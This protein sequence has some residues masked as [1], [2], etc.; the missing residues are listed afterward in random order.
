VGSALANPPPLTWS[1]TFYVGPST[2]K[3]FV[4]AL[5]KLNFE[6]TGVMAGFAIDRPFLNLGW[7]VAL[8]GEGQ[9]T[10]YLFGHRDTT[11]AIG[12]GAEANDPFGLRGTE[13]S[14][15]TGPSYALD[16]PYT[17]IGYSNHL[18]PAWRKKFLNYVSL[19]YAV[20]LTPSANW[21]AAFRLYHRSGAFGLYT[22]SDDD[23]LSIGIGIRHVF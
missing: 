12:L 5:Q 14:F 19:E 15:Y 9:V 13:L 2:T 3:F 1:T 17:S 18:W 11:F 23:G 16:P 6:P 10:E 7:D 8:S 21:A 20:A 22:E 4:A